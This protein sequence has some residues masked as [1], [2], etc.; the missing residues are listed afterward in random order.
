MNCINRRIVSLLMAA[1]LAFG[2]TPLSAFAAEPVDT[3]TFDSDTAEEQG[4]DPALTEPETIYTL[5]LTHIFRF[6]LSGK[7]V[8][9]QASE[10][11][12]LTGA[13]FEDGVCNLSR[14]AYDVEQLTVTKADA[15]RLEDFDGNGVH[16]YGA[17]IVYAVSS[18]WQVVRRADAEGKETLLR[19]VFCGKLEDYA[20]VPANVVRIKLSYKYS[21]TG[22]LAGIDAAAPETVEMTPEEQADG[23]YK[24]TWA[25]PTVEGF[26]IVLDPSE[27][28]KYVKNPPKGTETPAELE[29]ALERGDFDVDIDHHTIYYYQEQSGQETHPSYQNRYSTEYNQAWNAARWLEVT[30][31]AGYYAQAVSG[32]DALPIVS[33]PGANPLVNPRL[34]VTLTEAQLASAMAGDGLDITVYY[35]RNAAWYTVNHWV[36]KTLSGLMDFTGWETKTEGG[37]EYVRLDQ[38]TFQGRVGALTRAAAKTDGL[39]EELEAIGFSQKLIENSDITNA[40]TVVDI[41]YKA[42]DSYRVIFDTDYTYIPRQQVALGSPVNFTGITEPKRTGYTFAGWRYLKKNA[43]PNPDGSY[44]D[45]Q[46]SELDKTNPALTVDTTLIAKAKLQDTGGVLALHLYPK[47]EP[48]T[49]QV[50]VILWTEDLTG[51]DDVQAI[52]T[53]GNSTVEGSYYA[54]K[55]AGY[56]GEPVTH[57]PQLGTADPHYSNVG[58]FTITLD[59]DS[60]L[61]NSGALLDTIQSQVTEKFKEVMGQENG[62]DVD[63]FYAQKDFEILHEESNGANSAAATASGDGK[64]IIYVYF[65][66]NIYTLKFRYYGSM[67]GQGWGSDYYVAIRTD[68]F[69]KDGA[70]QCVVDGELNFAYGGGNIKKAATVTSHDQMPVPQTITIKAKYGADLRNVWPVS[71]PDEYVMVEG[72]NGPDVEAA[73]ISWAV[74]D[75]KYR[76]DAKNGTNHA[77]EYTIMGVYAS[78]GSEIIAKPESPAVTHHLVAYWCYNSDRSYYRYTHCYEVPGLDVT[79][80]QKVG[81]FNNDTS[82]P[83]NFLYLV[84]TDA[85]SIARYEFTDL[86]Q[87]SY[88]NGTITYNDPNGAYYAVRQYTKDGVTRY[89][90]VARQ[91]T[92]VSTNSIEKQTPSA[93]LHMTRVND[94]PEHSTQYGDGAGRPGN[95]VGT[96]DA[97]Y[98]LYFYYD[99][100]RYTITYMVPSDNITTAAEVTLGTISLPY[101]ALVTQEKYGFALDY[102]DTNQTKTGSGANKYPWTVSG[103]AVSVCPDRSERGT[104]VWKFKGWGLGPAGLNMQWTMPEESEAQGQADDAFAIAANLRLYAIWETPTYTVTFHLNGG[105]AG[106][107]QVEARIPANTRYSASGSIPRPLREGYTLAGWYLADENGIVTEPQTAFDFDQTITENK[108]VAAV[109]TAV[110]TERFDYT[111]YD[112]AKTLRDADK[113][114]Y[115]ATVQISN[116]QIVTAGGETYFVLEKDSQ[117]DQVFL[118]GSVLNLP[119]SMHTG[120]V[121]RQTNQTL[122]MG[123]ASDTYNVIFFYEPITTGQHTVS[124]VLAGTETGAKEVVKSFTVNADQIVVTPRSVFLKELPGYALVNPNGG[125][126]EQVSAGQNLKWIDANGTA[127][128]MATL[129]GD[130]IPQTVTYLV[131]PIEYKI[132]YQNAPGSPA[133]ADAALT[134]VHN[135][136]TYTV[137]DNFT[138]MNP[139]HVYDSSKWYQFSHWSLGGN[140]TTTGGGTFSTLTVDAGTTGDLVFVANWMEVTDTGNLT[141][142]KTVAGSAGETNRD[143]HFTVTLNTTTVSGTFGDMTFTNGVASFTLKHGESRTVT[144]LPVGITY[145]VTETEANQNGY[146]TTAAGDTGTITNGVTATAA[147]TNTKTSSGGGSSG[148]SI[149]YFL[150]Y[151]TGGGEKYKDERYIKNTL[152]QLEKVPVRTGYKFTG[153]YADAGLTERITEIRMTGSRT[154]YAGWE[155]TG[156]PDWLNGKDHFAYVVGYPDGTVRPLT[157]ISRAEVVTIFFRLLNEDIRKENLTTSNSFSDVNEDMWFNTAVSTMEKLGIVKGRAPN[158][159]DP[160][161]PITR[162]EFA[163]ICTRFDSAQPSGGGSFTDISGCWAEAEIKCAAALGWIEGYPDGTFR[164]ANHIT[165]AEAITLINR[166]LGRLPGDENDLLD[167]MKVWPD[168]QPGAWYYLAV[169]EATNS[170]EFSRKDEQYEHWTKLITTPD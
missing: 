133:A 125:G 49:T 80:A 81:V 137:K 15:V 154:V 120:Y 161:A 59:T 89:Y 107:E 124:F 95:R 110:S 135:P 113:G 71:R 96:A 138:A 31:E 35:R 160:N 37:V 127:K 116:G 86:M 91:V 82:N 169:Q 147:F 55:Y 36:P 99:R 153:W 67:W 141:V 117:K 129:K 144:G 131:E 62:V 76:E 74:T 165:R 98:D 93:R 23:T 29:T 40:A 19:E 162:A 148:G 60:S 159:F 61:L 44:A 167:G 38:E 114:K 134:A 152:V 32:N 145:A 21:N 26:R 72:E 63:Q 8:S 16:R 17:Q 111:V 157:D 105:T 2:L 52:A 56:Q 34:E 58:S 12:S 13:D 102:T 118:A 75:G 70:G 39:Y 28:N 119:A 47:W 85:V 10:D 92:A 7:N 109:W 5:H 115:N 68:G 3:P 143:F 57:A 77:N 170:H 84:P 151:E 149:H 50:R 104:A 166:M 79:G 90:A 30:G 150:H 14:F 139:A 123:A 24:V 106:K 142:S 112:V 33:G 88:Q 64:T 164:P 43:A 155:R 130:A 158:L 168:N 22:G 126:Y 101:G 11:I 140:T 132:T 53:G 27:L 73:V 136:A 65:T 97:P 54:Q 6:Q 94:T 20:F 66:R 121:P 18:G 69:S 146:S 100:E 78:M 108:H 48:A 128:D 45:D 103:S 41:Y 163:V 87:V 46:Y 83:Q 1:L 42:A 122:T 51:T 25:L 9:V 156:I 4:G